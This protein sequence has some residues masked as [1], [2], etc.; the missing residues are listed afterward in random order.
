MS[1]LNSRTKIYTRNL[2]HQSPLILDTETTGLGKRDEVL[3]V[4]ITDHTGKALFSSLVKPI[5]HQSWLSAEAMNG[6]SPAMVADCPTFA[7][8]AQQVASLLNGRCVTG[9]NVN[10]DMTMLR[11][12]ATMHKLKKFDEWLGFPHLDC[13]MENYAQFNKRRFEELGVVC[14]RYGVAVHEAHTAVGDCQM[15]ANLLNVWMGEAV[16]G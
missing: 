2:L 3:S 8:I 15:I 5:L 9:W 10:F 11:Q 6:I 4:A 1:H 14:C 12:S 7:V 13:V 16:S